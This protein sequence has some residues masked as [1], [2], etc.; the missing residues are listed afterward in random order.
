M[1]ENWREEMDKEAEII[2]SDKQ[3]EMNDMF[4]IVREVIKVNSPI[5]TMNSDFIMSDLKP[6]IISNTVMTYVREQLSI[7]EIIN[8]YLREDW[9]VEINEEKKKKFRKWTYKGVEYTQEIKNIDYCEDVNRILLNEVFSMVN[10][11]RADKAR[12]INALVDYIRA[13][14]TGGQV[15]EQQ[16]KEETKQHIGGK[17]NPMNWG[18]KKEGGA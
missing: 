13:S 10:L 14:A 16:Q 17:L 9:I 11:S 1:A 6:E 8:I 5:S 3:T 12:V 4:D 7:I 15:V 2:D 18:Q